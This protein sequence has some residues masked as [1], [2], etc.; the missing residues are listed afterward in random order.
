MAVPNVGPRY[1]TDHVVVTPNYRKHFAETIVQQKPYCVNGVTSDK[2][3]LQC[4]S[5]TDAMFY[6]VML[7]QT[8]CEKCKLDDEKYI[9]LD[10][11]VHDMTDLTEWVPILRD[12]EHNLILQHKRTKKVGLSSINEDSQVF[13]I[14][15]DTRLDDV[16]NEIEVLAAEYRSKWSPLTFYNKPIYMYMNPTHSQV[17]HVITKDEYNSNTHFTLCT[18]ERGDKSDE[19]DEGDESTNVNNHDDEPETL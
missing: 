8:T 18:G 6:N 14:S 19:E 10:T 15:T 4:G 13:F 2:T 5:F 17:R 1:I 3:C 9:D 11:V 16:L 7:K 12:S